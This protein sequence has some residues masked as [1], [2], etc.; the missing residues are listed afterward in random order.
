MEQAYL[1]LVKEFVE[2][3]LGYLAILVDVDLGELSTQLFLHLVLQL[4]FQDSLVDR[5]W[6]GE[7][8]LNV[9]M[10]V[11][12]GGRVGRGR[13]RRDESVDIRH[14]FNYLNY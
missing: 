13:P 1:G 11:V 2:F 8:L 9:L 12:D 3:I 7:T 6:V 5:V 4:I 14:F 10:G